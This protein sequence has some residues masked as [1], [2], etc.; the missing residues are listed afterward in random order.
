MIN[1]S[2]SNGCVCRTALAPTGLSKKNCTKSNTKILVKR[3]KSYLPVELKA[4]PGGSLSEAGAPLCAACHGVST[5]A[6][7]CTEEQWSEDLQGGAVE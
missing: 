7:A 2:I 4:S 6:L 5:H 3:T 1:K